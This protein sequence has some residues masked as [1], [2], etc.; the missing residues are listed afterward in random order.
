MTR[1]SGDIAPPVLTSALY[2]QYPL[3]KRR[4][5]PRASPDATEEKNPLPLPGIKLQPFSP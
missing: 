4:G 2:A 5:D 3:D 1:E